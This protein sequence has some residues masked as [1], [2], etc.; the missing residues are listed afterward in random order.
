MLMTILVIL[1]IAFVFLELFDKFI[2]QWIVAKQSTEEDSRKA[3]RR[4]MTFEC[5]VACAAIVFVILVVC[6][7]ITI[8]GG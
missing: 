2:V 6:K 4:C 1:G 7:V 3:G 5:I 8:T